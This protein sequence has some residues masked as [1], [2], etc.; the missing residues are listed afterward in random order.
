MSYMDMLDILEFKKCVEKLDV[1]HIALLWPFVYLDFKLIFNDNKCPS[2]TKNTFPNTGKCN[3]EKNI[4]LTSI[5]S[6]IYLS[7]SSE[8]SLHLCEFF[9]WGCISLAMVLRTGNNCMK[10]NL[11]QEVS[12]LNTQS[13]NNKSLPYTKERHF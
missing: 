10:G 8:T 3:L 2:C 7:Q 5:V 12:L 11:Q 4:F 6:P 1:L 9:L 13:Y